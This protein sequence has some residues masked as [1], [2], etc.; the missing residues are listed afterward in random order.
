MIGE[1]RAAMASSEGELAFGLMALFRSDTDVET[2]AAALVVAETVIL[3][4]RWAK[5]QFK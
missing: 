2:E 1:R 5:A 3:L 4:H